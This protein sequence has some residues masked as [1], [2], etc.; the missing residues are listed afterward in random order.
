MGW[1]YMEFDILFFR[2]NVDSL[3]V[4]MGEYDMSTTDEPLDFVERK[5]K[6]LVIHPKYQGSY[7]DLALNSFSKLHNLVR[8]HA[9]KSGKVFYN[10]FNSSDTEFQA[11]AYGIFSDWFM[12]YRG[13]DTNTHDYDVGLLRLDQSL[14]FQDN[15][16]PICLPEDDR[17]FIGETAWVTGWGDLYDEGIYA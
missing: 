17:D 13:E 6:T 15:I 14:T 8:K 9:R 1:I 3:F 12:K 5:V 7:Q 2:I 16:M 10:P 11:R 4:R